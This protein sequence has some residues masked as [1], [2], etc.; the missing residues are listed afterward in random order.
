MEKQW[1][2]TDRRKPKHSERNLFRCHFVFNKA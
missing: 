1:N 2:Y